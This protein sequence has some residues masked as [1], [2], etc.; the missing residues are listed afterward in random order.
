MIKEIRIYDDNGTL[1]MSEPISPDGA[2]VSISVSGLTSTNLQA[3]IS[4]IITAIGTISVGSGY[5][6]GVVVDEVGTLDTA[7]GKITAGTNINGLTLTQ[8]LKTA[9][10]TASA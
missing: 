5:T 6:S 1:L 10:G 9:F 8:L 2:N 7:M 4:E 3:A